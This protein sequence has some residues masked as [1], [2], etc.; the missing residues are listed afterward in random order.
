G[1]AVRG[2]ALRVATRA[3]ERTSHL[4]LLEHFDLVADFDVV[5]AL[6][7]DAAFHAGTHFGDVV[8]EATQG[9]QLAFEDHH[10]ITQYADR[11][12]TEDV[13]F[14]HHATSNRTELRRTEYVTDL[15][16]TQDVLANIAAEHTGECFLDV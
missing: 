7:P 1:R 9:L 11:T 12:V 3:L 2:R 14:N 6:H 4:D 16:N 10:V 5:V 15:S 13:A 8:L